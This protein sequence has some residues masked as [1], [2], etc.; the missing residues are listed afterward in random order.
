MLE[1]HD[2]RANYFSFRNKPPQPDALGD[3]RLYELPSGSSLFISRYVNVVVIVALLIGIF[4]RSYK[5]AIAEVALVIQAIHLV[6]KIMVVWRPR[7][8][9]TPSRLQTNAARLTLQSEHSGYLSSVS[10]IFSELLD[11]ARPI[12]E[13]LCMGVL[14]VTVVALV[15]SRPPGGSVVT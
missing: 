15:T 6:C 2:G 5:N 9:E 11:G 8:I 14:C 7:R 3:V 4:D 10:L 13:I 12:G 1:F